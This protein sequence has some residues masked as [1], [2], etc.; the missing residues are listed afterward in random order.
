[1]GMLTF[2]TEAKVSITVK[3][4]IRIVESDGMPDHPTGEFPND[5]NP[6]TMIAK[7]HRFQM[8]ADPKPAETT[9]ALGMWPFGVALD[10]VPFDP[11][12]AE[13]WKRN[14]RSGWQYEPMF[15]KALGIDKYN[16]HV[17]PDGSYHY[18]GAPTYLTENAPKDKPVLVG[19]AAD[20]FPIYG[21][22]GY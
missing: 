8:P 21:P 17:Q 14:P 9:A 3:D 13:W 18:H 1:M 7:S 15:E 11:F 6:N 4:G 2:S 20:G 12:A 5:D 19:Y 16:A 22:K 10:G